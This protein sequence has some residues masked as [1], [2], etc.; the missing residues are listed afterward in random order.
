MNEAARTAPADPEARLRAA[1]PGAASEPDLVALR[2]AVDARVAA[3]PADQLARRR[4]VPLAARV[5]AVAAAALVVG[6]GGGYAVGAAQRD[7]A[8]APAIAVEGAPEGAP[9]EDRLA[10]GP[11]AASA[12]GAAESAGSDAVGDM[13]AP[14]WSGRATFTASGLSD[15]RTTGRAWS[16]DAAAAFTEQTV[17]DAAAALGVDGTPAL[18]DGMWSAGPNDGTAAT[19]QLY[20]DGTGSFSYYDPTKDPWACGDVPVT[21]GGGEDVSSSDLPVEPCTQRD[22]G[23]APTTDEAAAQLTDALGRLGVDTEAYEVVGEEWG[24]EQWTYATAHQVVDG[25][26]SGLQWSASFTGAGLQSLYGS[27]APLVDLGEYDVV[28][29]TEAVER[30]SDPRF[31]SGGMPIAYAEGSEP[32]VEEAPSA[33]EVPGSLEPG[34]SLA[35]RVDEVT[36][37]EARLGGALHTLTDGASVLVPTY[38]LVSDSGAIWSVLAVAEEHL[39]FGAGR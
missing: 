15:E 12:A 28:S 37:V 3:A 21:E 16:F 30:L 11:Q 6:G 9:A 29:P 13:A 34:S 20:P 33:P 19:V 1:D 2:A 32:R 4:R 24:D 25:R 14:G 35:W 38:E 7:D 39:D 36:I 27:L 17:A 10:V 5:A 26:R 8:P 22:L 31:A 23:P 18:V